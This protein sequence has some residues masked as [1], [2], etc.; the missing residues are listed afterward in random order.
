MKIIEYNK[1]N[2]K[3]LQKIMQRGDQIYYDIEETVEDII[4][5]VREN[6]DKSLLG[7]TEKFDG[8]K[9]RSLQV[10]D[11]EFEVA[12]KKVPGKFLKAIRV[13]IENQKKFQEGIFQK[14]SRVIETKPGI[15]VW[16]EWRP[17][18]KVG[19]Y[20]PGG[21]ARYP[22][23][24]VMVG[25]P[26]LVSGCKEI[27]ICTPPEANGQINPTVL[28]TAA[29]L[30]VKKVFKVGGAQAI[31]AMA[32]GT[33]TIPKTY[34]VFGAGNSYVTLAKM[35]VFG[36]VDIDMPAGP[37]EVMV[38]A[39]NNANVEYVAA[40]LISQCEHGVESS[41]VLITNSKE[42]AEKVKESCYAQAEGLETKD[43]IKKS[44]D[45]YGATIIV[46]NWESAA[47]VVNEFAPEHLELVLQD[48][49]YFRRLVNNAG[50]VFLGQYAS[51]PAGDYATGSNHV[52]P[53]N[54]YAKMFEGLSVD[55]FGKWVEFQE[56]TKDGLKQIKEAIDVLASE[57]G[58][59]AHANAVDVRFKN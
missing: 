18:E 27:V 51:E 34:K 53:T 32:Y 19:L 43:T 35:K 6:G 17:I 26:A 45:A 37:S 20:I 30:G 59:P 49:D 14:K 5:S 23:S 54:G 7:Y 58:L 13:A 24:I 12:Y 3:E 44:L 21:R 8:A 22:S 10:S 15:R 57:E 38:V 29:E 41:A 11:E 31:A 39:D 4:R 50:S 52:L 28:V 33:E 48:Y 47:E 16:R 55:S 56:L 25:V 40:D 9:L 42:F 1:T 46:K 2:Q 36:E